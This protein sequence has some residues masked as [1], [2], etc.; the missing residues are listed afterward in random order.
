MLLTLKDYTLAEDY[1][2]AIKQQKTV[3]W[4]GRM[5]PIDIKN[6]LPKGEILLILNLILFLRG[7]LLQIFTQFR[8]SFNN[9]CGSHLAVIFFH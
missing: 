6:I 3:L 4:E 2:K 5:M 1:I 9:A 8:L 7:S